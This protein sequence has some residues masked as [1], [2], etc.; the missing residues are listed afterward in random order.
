MIRALEGGISSHG[1]IVAGFFS[2]VADHGAD[3]GGSSGSGAGDGTE[4]SVGTDV[5][6]QQGT[7]H[8]AQDGHNEVDQTLCDTTLIHDITGQDEEGDG[9]QAEL[10]H[11]DEGTLCSSQHGDIQRNNSQDGGQ[12][13]NTDGV[14]DRHAQEE[15]HQHNAQNG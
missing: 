2:T 3:G 8:L 12:G 15:Q 5:G 10:G 11:T 1:G 7:G 13:R 14:R 4:Q 6:N 9:G